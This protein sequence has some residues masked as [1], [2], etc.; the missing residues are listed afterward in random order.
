M[1]WFVIPSLPSPLLRSPLLPPLFL[2][3]PPLQTLPLPP[4]R[5][6]I[7]ATDASLAGLRLLCVDNDPEILAG[8]QALLG[9]WQ[10]DAHCATTVDGALALAGTA[11]EVLLV[12]YDLH[13]RLDGLDTLDALRAACGPVPGNYAPRR[14]ISDATRL[15]CRGR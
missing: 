14:C 11:P 12:D 3:P 2:P 8:M 6:L 10:V 1:A 7:G 4:P 9:R 13:D 15:H 5:P